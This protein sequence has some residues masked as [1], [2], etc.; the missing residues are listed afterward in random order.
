ML[1]KSIKILSVL[2]LLAVILVIGIFWLVISRPA[3][4]HCVDDKCV[5]VVDYYQG[6]GY[7]I[8]IY[9]EKLYSRFLLDKRDHIKH[10]IEGNELCLSKNL[11]ENKIQIS[12]DYLPTY[13]T[14]KFKNLQFMLREQE[15]CLKD[16]IAMQDLINMPLFF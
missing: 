12:M 16:E 10:I 7:F 5:T 13:D 9:E 15:D 2:L 14:H 6:G 4:Y 11:I 1:K 3:Y 8:R